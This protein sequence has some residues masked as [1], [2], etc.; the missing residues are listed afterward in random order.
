[1]LSNALSGPFLFSHRLVRH[2]VVD[3]L[4]GGFDG[5]QRLPKA[6][7]KQR[8]CSSN[9]RCGRCIWITHYSRKRFNRLSRINTSGSLNIRQDPRPSVRIS[10]LSWPKACT[11]CS[12]RHVPDV[13]CLA[14]NLNTTDSALALAVTSVMLPAQHCSLLSTVP[15]PSCPP[16]TRVL[17]CHRGADFPASF[18]GGRQ[19]RRPPL[20]AWACSERGLHPK[21]ESQ[22]SSAWNP[23]S[24][25]ALDHNPK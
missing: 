10:R 15:S 21:L 8:A 13:P 1:M 22:T 19:G 11:V 24:Q 5:L 6:T 14:R 16:H 25:Q 3:V 18:G 9:L 4:I 20:D 12:S 7:I 2:H 23:D 17:A